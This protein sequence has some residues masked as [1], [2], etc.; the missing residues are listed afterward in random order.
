MRTSGS[1]EAKAMA[2]SSVGCLKQ[3]TEISIWNTCATAVLSV[4]PSGSGPSTSA[5][6]EQE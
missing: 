1:A 5:S 3:F 2:F 4:P 6:K